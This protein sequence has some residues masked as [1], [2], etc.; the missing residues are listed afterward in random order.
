MNEQVKQQIKETL[1]AYCGR[2][3]SQN[4][5][6]NSLRNVSSATI[7]Q[8]LNDK[9][10]L[11]ADEMWRKVAAQIGYSTENWV[12][13]PTTVSN[14]LYDLLKDA[15]SDS[16][17]HAIIGRAGG[18]KTETSKK[19][20]VENNNSFHITCSEYWNRKTFLVELLEAMGCD[21]TGYT[22]NEMVRKVVAL[23]KAMENPQFIWDEADKL[24][25]QVLYFFITLYNHF[26]D[27]CSIILLATDYLKKR[28]LRGVDLKK[29]GYNEI[30]SRIGRRFI[31]LPG[32]TYDDQAAI[33]Q[34]NGIQTPN[35]IEDIIDSSESDLRRVKKLT[36]ANIKKGKKND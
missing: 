5:A 8:I 15:Q 25:D 24:N 9:W 26:E 36:K 3:A 1:K 10:E 13:V 11:I 19:Y 16:G 27:K 23:I 7:S 35:T 14:T 17:V 34:A 31:E 20:V 4:K 33:C 29:K 30:Y 6:A 22:V 28:I 2:F 32:N 21:S 12:V 18:G